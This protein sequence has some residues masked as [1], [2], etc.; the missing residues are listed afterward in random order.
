MLIQRKKMSKSKS[1][2]KSRHQQTSPVGF[3][4]QTS[5]AE[6]SAGT[7]KMTRITLRTSLKGGNWVFSA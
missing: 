3:Q 7:V 6:S 5:H 1:R 2:L 4:K